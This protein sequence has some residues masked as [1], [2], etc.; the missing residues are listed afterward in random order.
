M[1]KPR[2]EAAYSRINCGRK[3][4]FTSSG[5]SSINSP[6]G[7]P[8]TLASLP[9]VIVVVAYVDGAINAILHLAE[10][11]TVRYTGGLL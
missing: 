3:I 8:S 5:T 11:G 4:D 10:N 2:A 7:T 9:R 6:G 1:Q